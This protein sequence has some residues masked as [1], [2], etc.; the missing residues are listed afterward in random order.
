MA[1]LSFDPTEWHNWHEWR[2]VVGF[3]ETSLVGTVYFANYVVW[4]G[5]CREA[6]IHRCY[7]EITVALMS[8]TLALVTK[9]CSCEFVGTR[10][11]YA[12]EELLIKM[13]IIS[14]RGGRCTLGFA[15][16]NLSKEDE[17]VA[18][19]QQ[20]VHCYT[21]SGDALTPATFPLRMLDAFPSASAHGTILD[22][23]G[24]AKIFVESQVKDAEQAAPADGASRR[25]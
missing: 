21:R 8:G 14:F 13:S 11:L 20:E 12:L 23:I 3:E 16:Y 18:Q 22:A 2:H 9:A 15:Y 5:S 25:R 6:F 4:Q 19:G 17:L 7:P 24:D 1:K 10:G